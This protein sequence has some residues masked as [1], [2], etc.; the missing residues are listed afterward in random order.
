MIEQLKTIF[1][2]YGFYLWP[3]LVVVV[4]WVIFVRIDLPKISEINRVRQQLS[5]IKER[6]AKLSA[7]SNLLTSLDEEKLKVDLEKTNLV[8]PDGKD[9]PSILR[10]L[11]ISASSSGIFLEN[12]DL[13]PGKLATKG[14]TPQIGGE[15]S[16]EIPLRVAI[17]GTTPQITAYLEK[18]TSIGRSLGVKNLEINFG[19]GTASAKVNLELV[20]YFLLPPPSVG[21]GV[22]E[23][24]PTMRAQE[25]DALTKISQ[26][27]LLAPAPITSPAGKTDLF[28]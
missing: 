25:N 13:T 16:N 6:L 14:A 26:R 15:K 8:L 5:G 2:N 28:K 4:I 23:A 17:N 7:K 3:V 18:I 24:L 11:E 27:E 1:K 21:G 22:E 9:A 19:E 12:L 10:N 20:A